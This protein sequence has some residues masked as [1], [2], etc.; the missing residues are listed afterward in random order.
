MICICQSRGQDVWW[1]PNRHEKRTNSESTG[2][3]L[4][5]TFADS[6]NAFL[7]FN[8][9]PDPENQGNFNPDLLF[10]LLIKLSDYRREIWPAVI[11]LFI[12]TPSDFCEPTWYYPY[13]HDCN[14]TCLRLHIRA[15]AVRRLLD[16]IRDWLMTDFICRAD[17][18]NAPKICYFLAWWQDRLLN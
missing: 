12:L 17:G 3:L 5:T 10:D 2:L 7:I 15:T 4:A 14:W 18:A 9:T 13:P 16:P 8:T 1:G 11:W 6:K